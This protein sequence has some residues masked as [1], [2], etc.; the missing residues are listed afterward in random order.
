MSKFLKNVTIF[1]VKV[2]NKELLYAAT[3]TNNITL[4]IEDGVHK[5]KSK[6]AQ[7]EKKNYL[8]FH[9]YMK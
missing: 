6:V 4:Q 9:M 3:F 8:G 7:N 1:L 2:L 5:R